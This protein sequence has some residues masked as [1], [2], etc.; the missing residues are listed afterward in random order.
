M[1]DSGGKTELNAE[2][3]E[4]EKIE[5]LA[6]EKAEKAAMQEA[7][8]N[9]LVIWFP[10]I[11]IAAVMI[12]GGAPPELGVFFGVLALV[13]GVASAIFAWKSAYEKWYKKYLAELTL[14]SGSRGRNEN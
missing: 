14:T 8:A 6:R 4:K 1:E 7:M 5:R 9:N 12:L 13:A 3:I 11:F 2:P 10:L